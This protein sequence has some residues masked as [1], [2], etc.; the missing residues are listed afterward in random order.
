[1]NPLLKF[2]FY[3][4]VRSRWAYIYTGFYLLSTMV[5]MMLSNDISKTLI[6]MT[7][8]TLVLTPLIGVLFGTTYYY[9]SR[10]FINLLLGQPI[11]RTNIFFS[12]YG[13]LVITLCLSLIIG[14]GVPLLGY[15]VLGSS[16]LNIF[17]LLLAAGCILSIIFSA[18]A[19]L[20]AMLF[21]DK[22]KGLSFS[23]FI[24]LFFAVIYDGIILLLLFIFKDY[25]LDKMTIGLITMNPIDLSRILI[26]MKLDISAMMGYTGA[27]LTKFLGQ[28]WGTLTI[29]GSLLIWIGVPLWLIKRV[30]NVK[31]F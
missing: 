13:G 25:P 10:E 31:D 30:S 16:H 26:T 27:V 4:M 29:V 11:S 9:N 19:F 20:L 2:S 23:I 21:N 1:M 7:N 28:L 24:W 22:V 15:G 18:I 14:I 3:E 5:L 6:S 17:L 12:I 8:I